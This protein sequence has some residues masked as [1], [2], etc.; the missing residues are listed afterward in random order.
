M[1]G[2]L[3]THGGKVV[4]PGIAGQLGLVVES[5]KGGKEAA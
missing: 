3:L 4:H 5:P 2:A 1:R